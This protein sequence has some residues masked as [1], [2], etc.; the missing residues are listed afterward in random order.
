MGFLFAL[1]GYFGTVIAA[2]VMIMASISFI[3]T[4]PPLPSA[5]TDVS[6]QQS[7]KSQKLSLKQ[8]TRQMAARAAER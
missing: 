5:T 4:Q 8:A 7:S 6:A 3:F 2:G 1:L